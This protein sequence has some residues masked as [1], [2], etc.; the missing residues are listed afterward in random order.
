MQT[1][2]Q[3]YGDL[4]GLDKSWRVV[5]VD[6]KIDPAEVRIFLE[7]A[8]SA[9]HCSECGKACA[10]KDH[11][12]ERQWR[13]LDTMQFAATWSGCATMAVHLTAKVLSGR[14]DLL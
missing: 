9:F 10:L 1:L 11:A 4:L 6:L 13:H 2:P 12:P 3:H 7:S 8:G 5:S 14:K